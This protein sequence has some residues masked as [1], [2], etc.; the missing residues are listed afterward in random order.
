M[1]NLNTAR[2]TVNLPI[3]TTTNYNPVYISNNGTSDTFS[4][5]VEGDIS[6]TTAGAVEAMWHI[7]EATAGGSN[8]NLKLGW[9]Q[10]QENIDFVRANAKVG[11]YTTTW[12]QENSGTVSGSGPYT[13]SASGITSFSPFA[14]MNFSAL[15]TADFTKSELSVYPNPFT[16][17]FNVEVK[18]NATI[19]IFDMSGK[20]VS[21]NFLKKGRNTIDKAEFSSGTYLYQIKNIK[22]EITS[23]GKLLKN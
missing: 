8:V 10:Q 16:E 23:F 21:I 19:S 14:V 1:E 3:G 22:G 4:A 2:G 9:N 12:N 15:G 20:L 6:N 11:H 13:I 5:R 18:E 17:S 7:S